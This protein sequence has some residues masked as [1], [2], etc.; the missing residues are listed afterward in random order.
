VTDGGTIIEAVEFGVLQAADNWASFTARARWSPSGEERA[1][2]V[3]LDEGDP[4]APGATRLIVEADGEMMLT[5][6]V[7]GRAN[8]TSP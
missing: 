8:V 4:A 6:S 5:G 2:T 7:Q 1:I 3:I